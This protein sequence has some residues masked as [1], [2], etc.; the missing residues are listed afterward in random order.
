MGIQLRACYGHLQF[1]L[2][3]GENNY[4]KACI[5]SDFGTITP[6]HIH[7]GNRGGL[8]YI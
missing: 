4:T 1:K 8:L 6:G 3:S 2:W 7:L 5:V